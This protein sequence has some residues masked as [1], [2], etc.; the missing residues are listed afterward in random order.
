[1]NRVPLASK[2]IPADCPSG[3]RANVAPG[4]GRVRSGLLGLL[5]A[6]LPALVQAQDPNV[7]DEP[8]EEP[9]VIVGDL[10]EVSN[11]GSVGDISAFA[12][13]TISCNIGTCQLN[14]VKQTPEHPVI[15]QNMYRLKDGRFEQI[16]QSWVKHGFFALNQNFC[17][18]ECTPATDNEHLGVNCSDP[19][20]A[21][22]NGDQIRMGPRSE[23]NA[24]TGDL[25]YPYTG[26][27]VS[28][29]AIFKRL[30]VHNDDLDPALN[31]G[32]VYF[33]EAQYVT[34]DDT[35]AQNH[36]NNV[37]HR[38][39]EVATGGGFNISLL[40]DTAR[41]MPAVTIW[42]G[43]DAS[44]T[45]TVVQ[46]PGDGTY[47]IYS[48]A[49]D[50]EDGFWSY[51]YA[52]YN[53][54][55]HRSGGFFR[56]QL[57]P[58]TQVRNIGFHDVDYHSGEIYDGTDWMGAVVTD[59]GGN[60]VLWETESSDVN[61]DANALRWGTLYNFRF[62]ADVPP[63]VAD[64]TLGLFLPGSPAE[65]TVTAAAPSRCCAG[66]ACASGTDVDGDGV[67]D[68]D[69]DDG[70]DQ[71]WAAPGE[72]QS[73]ALQPD[74][75]GS[76]TLEWLPPGNLGGAAIT[77][78]VL[79]S[80]NPADFFTAVTCLPSA[81]PSIPSSSDGDLPTLGTIYNYLI[82]AMNACPG[83]GG[84]LGAGSSGALRIGLSCP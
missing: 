35:I 10:H 20:S 84:S 6:L 29:N 49:T 13:G 26:I 67:A 4:P 46:V 60:A 76:T 50:L 47:H 66:P 74:G 22:L 11:H 80:E 18:S 70:N 68:C 40:G 77:Y 39:V 3:R 44:V 15:A 69:C 75:G 28:G 45:D 30:Q 64:V 59:A 34:H 57:F 33:V 9:D 24:S 23:I 83:M 17:S 55:S 52:A 5:L 71:V 12:L 43:S 25:P 38:Q 51:E 19:Y 48:K 81:D 53:L 54:N 65:M 56:V 82:R 16:G 42:P 73:L 63:V 32:A 72:V 62:E 36:D 79:R 78:D 1:M 58:G 2:S 27:N 14:W 37:S 7:C 41:E 8:G 61:P 31:P 21:F